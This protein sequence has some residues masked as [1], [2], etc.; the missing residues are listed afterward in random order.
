MCKQTA[1]NFYLYL[2]IHGEA[3]M[4]E[5]ESEEVCDV[6]LESDWLEMLEKAKKP[7]REKIEKLMAKII[8]TKAQLQLQQAETAVEQDNEK[9]AVVEDDDEI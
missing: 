8:I 9:E 5:E 4:G 2:M 6:L 1:E 7:T 3:L